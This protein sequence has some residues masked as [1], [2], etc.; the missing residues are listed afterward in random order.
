MAAGFA[1]GGGGEKEEAEPTLQLLLGTPAP[2]NPSFA[3][4]EDDGEGVDGGPLASHEPQLV[5]LDWLEQPVDV[6]PLP[7]FAAR[8]EDAGL[9][10]TVQE[11]LEDGLGRSSVVIHNLADGRYVAIN[12]SEVYYGASLYKMSVLLEV[13]KQADAG[14][15]DLSEVVTLEEEYAENDIETLELLG[16][17]VGDTLTIGD[18]VKAMIIVSDTSTAV[19]LQETVGGRNADDTLRELGIEDTSFNNRALPATA[20]DMVVLMEAVASGRGVS[21][22]SRLRMLQLLLQEGYKDGV[23]AGAPE[24]TAIAHKTGSYNDATHDVALVWGPAGPYVISVMTDQPNNWPLVAK[25]SVAVWD[26]FAANP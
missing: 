7:A 22:G 18:A 9:L 12:E 21:E 6:P 14:E 5:S 8:T 4:S 16:L 11:A 13:F 23:A 19:L 17:E 2:V 20:A 10:A 3:G 24:G 26:Y 1:C 25:V 15:L